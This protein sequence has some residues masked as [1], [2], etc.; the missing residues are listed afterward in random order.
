MNPNSVQNKSLE[1]TYQLSRKQLDT[2]ALYSLPIQVITVF[3]IFFKYYFN[4]SRNMS[5]L[6]ADINGAKLLPLFHLFWKEYL[7]PAFTWIPLFV[8]C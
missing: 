4:I 6:V 1:Y 3:I 2:P 8:K 7:L 5:S